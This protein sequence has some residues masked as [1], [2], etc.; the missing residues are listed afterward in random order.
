VGAWQSDEDDNGTVETPQS[1]DES[2]SLP[3]RDERGCVED[4]LEMGT[5]GEPLRTMD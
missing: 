2:E 3:G 4:K 1:S 5:S